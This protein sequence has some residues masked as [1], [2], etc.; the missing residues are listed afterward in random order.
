MATVGASRD[1]LPALDRGGNAS[2][3]ASA[4]SSAGLSTDSAALPGAFEDS[5]WLATRLGERVPDGRSG[6]DQLL[7]DV[8]A[9]LGISQEAQ[10]YL[11]DATKPEFV[12]L[13]AL[14]P[15]QGRIKKRDGFL[16]RKT[17]IEEVLTAGKIFSFDRPDP[18]AMIDFPIPTMLCLPMYDGS[19]IIG[20]LS[21]EGPSSHTPVGNGDFGR[22]QFAMKLLGSALAR[23][24]DRARYRGETEAMRTEILRLKEHQGKLE[25]TTDFLD[26]EADRRYFENQALMESFKKFLSPIVIEQINANPGLLKVGGVKQRVT[27]FFSD[28]R[29]FTALSETLDPNTIVTLLNEYFSVMT[30]TVHQYEGT[31]DKY[32]G[33]E[34]MALFGAPL[35]IEE[36]ATRAILCAVEMQVKLRTLQA[37]WLERGLPN[38]EVGIGIHT[39]EVTVGF[40]GSEEVLSYTAIGDSVNLA[41]RLC[42]HAGP[43]QI[44]ISAATASEM[45]QEI[46]LKPLP[47]F[48]PK[49]KS[50]PV[51]VF[52][53]DIENTLVAAG[54][55]G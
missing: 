26:K 20:L 18:Q 33:D 3:G 7:A 11:I 15:S 25:N 51:E 12:R 4:D 9:F 17:P 44:V 47:A 40:I 53:V 55:E 30:A 16:W 29:G 31:L 34:I 27:V 36:A 52:E 8:C 13:V 10:V 21:A 32:V 54:G 42:S 22:H 35:P 43:R 28:I 1:S 49:G 50:Q 14:F 37:S 46:L 45:R 48:V 2:A 38:F 6:N 24:F 39:G 19:E 5:L 41:A 23:R